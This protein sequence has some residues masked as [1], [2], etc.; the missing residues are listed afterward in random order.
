MRVSC[1]MVTLP[2]RREMMMRAAKAWIGQSHADR[3]LVVVIDQG[4]PA[5]RA[6]AVAALS[7]LGRADIR[8]VAPDAPLSLGALRNLSVAHATGE[9][10]C[11]W[12]DDDLHHP[13]R[14]ARQLAAMTQ[15]GAAATLLQDVMLYRAEPRTLHWLNWAATPAGGHPGTL[16]CR[17]DRMPAYVE[18]GPTARLGEDLDLLVRLQAGEAVL[19][20]AGEPHLYVYVT[21]SANS[22]APEHHNLLAERLAIS[23]GL[24]RRR[25]AGL[26]EGLRPFGLDGAS[27]EGF[28][29]LA[30]TL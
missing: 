23:Q 16:F 2:E 18:T 4:A 30:F 14:I 10:I 8:A 11:Q 9:A 3:E 20:Q 7:A 22:T 15:A 17:R 19:P 25:E 29:G 12:D 6:A 5:E 27:V 13:E 24:L 26:R 1:L 21:H 28:N